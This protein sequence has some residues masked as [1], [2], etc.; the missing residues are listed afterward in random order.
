MTPV[1]PKVQQ[2]V[3]QDSLSATKSLTECLF[4]GSL[5][6]P[7]AVN[8]AV[9]ASPVHVPVSALVALVHFRLTVYV[10]H[11]DCPGLYLRE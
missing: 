11:S 3:R 2:E 8:P 1:L 9:S 7:Q 4:A 6:S 5:S 10:V